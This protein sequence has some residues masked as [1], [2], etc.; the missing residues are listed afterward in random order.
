M[1]NEHRTDIQSGES[2]NTDDTVMLRSLVEKIIVYDEHMEI[3][4]RCGAVIGKK[5]LHK[6]IK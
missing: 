4:L 1:F 6:K 5:Y 2:M 3:H